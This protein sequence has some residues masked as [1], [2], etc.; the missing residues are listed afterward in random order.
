MSS[1]ADAGRKASFAPVADA[2]TRL[3]VLGSLPGEQSLAA[4][5]YYANP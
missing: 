1:A 4:A 3:L 2:R 5:Q